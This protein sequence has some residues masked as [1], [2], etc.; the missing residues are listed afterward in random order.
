MTSEIS[1]ERFYTRKRAAL[2]FSRLRD[3]HHCA[4][5][6]ELRKAT[7]SG[8]I[9]SRVK[10]AASGAKEFLARERS[11]RCARTLVTLRQCRREQY[12][13]ATLPDRSTAWGGT[14]ASARHRVRIRSSFLPVSRILRGAVRTNHNLAANVSSD[15]GGEP[16]A[17]R[18]PSGVANRLAPRVLLS[19]RA[20]GYPRDG[21]HS[22]R[23]GLLHGRGAPA[24]R[25]RLPP[26]LRTARKPR[27]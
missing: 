12:I 4:P 19:R 21:L 5:A 26:S 18:S 17:T 25:R 27:R 14:V 6:D 23:P 1:I 9:S 7:K 15:A 22:V 2:R 11:R 20:A 8:G 16:L 24:L 3:Q 10:T 13:I